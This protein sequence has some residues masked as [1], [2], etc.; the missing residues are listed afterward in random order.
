MALE[1]PNFKVIQKA[2]DVEIRDYA[3]YQVASCDVSDIAD[4]RQA[5]S[6]GFRYLFNYISG[7][8]ANS[9]KIAM[10]APVQQKPS[11]GGWRI[12][13]VV[14]SDVQNAG[15]PNPMSSRVEIE[16]VPGG[17]VAALSYRGLWNTSKLEELQGELI[18][19]IGALGYQPVGEAYSAVYNPPF[20]PPILRHNEVLTR[21]KKATSRAK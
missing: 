5:S 21:V 18:T 17:L 13:F 7:Q 2:G 11:A 16:D 3:P 8:N 20:T 1:R 9:Q 15:A 19:K 14:P 10:T 4:L 12:S 6:Y